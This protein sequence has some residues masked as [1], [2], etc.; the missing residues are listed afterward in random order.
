MKTRPEQYGDV[1]L[2]VPVGSSPSNIVRRQTRSWPCRTLAFVQMLL[3]FAGLWLF[4]VEDN[5]QVGGW[6][7]LSTILLSF[8]TERWGV[9]EELWRKPR[10]PA[11]RAAYRRHDIAQNV[12]GVGVFGAFMA[13]VFWGPGGSTAWGIALLGVLVAFHLLSRWT[14]WTQDRWLEPVPSSEAALAI[15]PPIAY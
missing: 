15:P 6:L 7:V 2:E 3:G 14:K 12:L 8:V 10:E 9:T 13:Y 1:V 5:S 11:A 4:K